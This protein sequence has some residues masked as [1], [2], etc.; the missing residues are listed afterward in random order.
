MSG[1]APASGYIIANFIHFYKPVFVEKFGH[2]R[3]SFCGKRLDKLH[4]F[5]YDI[6]C[7]LYDYILQYIIRQLL[8]RQPNSLHHTGC[9]K[10]WRYTNE[11]NLSAEKPRTQ[12]STWLHGPHEQQKR[13][14]GAGSSP[15]KG[16][17]G[18]VC[19]IRAY[20]GIPQFLSSENTAISQERRGCSALSS[21]RRAFPA[22]FI[23]GMAGHRVVGAGP[24]ES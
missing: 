23:V 21:G 4:I 24:K 1:F 15:R 10:E 16:P 18:A 20:N 14:Q 5:Y 11:E 22:D 13:P 17:Q 3:T 8:H 9:E 6:I 2:F 19:L 12:E 7:L